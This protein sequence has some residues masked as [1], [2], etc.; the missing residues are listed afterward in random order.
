MTYS[1]PINDA[2]SEDDNKDVVTTDGTGIEV[3]KKITEKPK[4]TTDVVE[5]DTVPKTDPASETAGPEA[6]SAPAQ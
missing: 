2:A 1:E 3:D 5:P 6:S 4:P